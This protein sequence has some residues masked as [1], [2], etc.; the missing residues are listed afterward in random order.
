MEQEGGDARPGEPVD[1]I[2]AASAKPQKSG[3][4]MPGSAFKSL[5]SMSFKRRQSQGV[6]AEQT[7]DSNRRHNHQY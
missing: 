1:S 2:E 3:L 5:K 7:G 6:S 4:S